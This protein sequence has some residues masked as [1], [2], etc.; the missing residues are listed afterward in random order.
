VY[1]KHLRE[2]NE[3]FQHRGNAQLI[4]GLATRPV[5]RYSELA[6]VIVETTGDLLS[7]T[8]INRCRL[9]LEAEGLLIGEGPKTHRTYRLTRRG[10]EKAALLEYILDAMEQRDEE[11]Q[12]GHDEMN[13]P[14]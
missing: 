13:E 12:P 14:R 1:D 10:R 4:L 2:L 7:A 3:I 11:S 8:E 6:R 9:R 5:L